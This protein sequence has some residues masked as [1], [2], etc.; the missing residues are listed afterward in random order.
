VAAEHMT[1]QSGAAPAYTDNDIQQERGRKNSVDPFRSHHMLVEPEFCAN[2]QVEDVA[3]VFLSNRECPFRC[4]MCDLW[5]NTTD[6]RVPVGAIPEQIR[7]AVQQLP[8]AQHIKLYNSGN[9]FDA[10]AIPPED[11]S[12]IASLVRGFATVIVENHPRLCHDRCVEF[13]DLCDTHLEIAIGLETSHEQTL[14]QLN[15]QMTTDDFARAC[16]FLLGHGIRVRAFILLKPPH[17]SEEQ[18]IERAVESTRFA[19]DHGVDCC[20]VIPTR[21]GNGIMK[22]LQKM[23]LFQPPQLRSLEKAIDETITWKRGRVFADLWEAEQFAE[24]PACATA[25]IARLN[26]IN[27]SQRAVPPIVCKRCG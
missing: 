24:C 10:Q 15:K 17:T 6:D 16:E 20:S 11:F 23:D 2:G 3:T 9:F 13:R 8:P 26:T 25:R 27:L 21:A 22:R 18:G 1:S 7:H 4:L 19:F 5:K 12:A 14:R